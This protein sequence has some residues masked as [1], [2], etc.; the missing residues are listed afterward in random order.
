MKRCLSIFVSLFVL[1]TTI[2]VSTETDAEVRARKDALDVAG[3]F[4]ND[5]FKI[6]DGHWC[7][8]VKPHDHALV[9]VNLYA[10]N[11]YWF[12]AGATEPVK[13]IAVS[14][15][16]ETGKQVT[17]ENYDNGEKAAAGFSPTNSGQYFVSIDLVDGDEGTFC[18]VYSYK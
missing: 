7:G 3:A 14:L 5:G 18:L 16:D 4:S 17:T 1:G 2:A 6:R 13:K 11:Q 12:S 9:A 15:Y 10:G 8:I